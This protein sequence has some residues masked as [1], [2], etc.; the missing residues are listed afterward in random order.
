[1]KIE[2]YAVSVQWG[3]G[4]HYFVSYHEDLKGASASAIIV[5]TKEDRNFAKRKN[6]GAKPQTHIWENIPS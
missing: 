1:M 3:G 4:Y 6:K 5:Q 2:R